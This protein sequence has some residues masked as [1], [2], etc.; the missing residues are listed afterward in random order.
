MIKEILNKYV[1]LGL[2]NGALVE[3]FAQAFDD[4]YLRVVE[5]DNGITIV[6]IDDISFAKQIVQQQQPRMQ[7]QQQQQPR[8]PAVER[9]YE[10]P[11]EQPMYVA[12]AGPT[13]QREASPLLDDNGFA[14]GLPAG[15]VTQDFPCRY[16]ANGFEAIPHR[17]GGR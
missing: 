17:R 2:N 5:L 3:G 6:K 8:Y 14:A 9:Q 7:Q 4:T 11:A 10:I 13:L 16:P 12:G 15:T 1:V